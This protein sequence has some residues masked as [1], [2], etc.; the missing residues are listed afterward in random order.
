MEIG[1][2]I[3]GRVRNEQWRAKNSDGETPKKGNGVLFPSKLHQKILNKIAT[4]VP[5]F[6]HMHF[7]GM[8]GGLSK[9]TKEFQI[10]NKGVDIL[11]STCERVSFHLDKST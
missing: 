9:T 6:K 11:V 4:E 5:E 8:A 2:E 3:G 1:K 7:R 10:L